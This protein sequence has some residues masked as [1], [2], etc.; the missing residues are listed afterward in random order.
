MPTYERIKNSAT[1]GNHG[2]VISLRNGPTATD[3]VLRFRHDLIHVLLDMVIEF[4]AK[5]FGQL[6]GTKIAKL[7]P[8]DAVSI[9]DIRV[10][11]LFVP[12]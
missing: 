4:V 3:F 10:I 2:G 1:T 9:T 12:W 11:R 8:C 5:I 7:E 6:K